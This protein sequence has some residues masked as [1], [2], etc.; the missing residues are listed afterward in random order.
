[1][2]NFK[3]FDCEDDG[4][5]TRSRS[6]PA[7][8]TPTPEPEPLPMLVGSQWVDVVMAEANAAGDGG[9][10]L[11]VECEEGEE[12]EDEASG[13]RAVTW[14][15]QV[16]LAGA[17]VPPEQR[18]RILFGEVIEVIEAPEGEVEGVREVDY[19]FGP[20]SNPLC[21]DPDVAEALLAVLFEMTAS[22]HR[23][24]GGPLSDLMD[25]IVPN[26]QAVAA[27]VDERLGREGGST[28]LF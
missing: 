10:H 1:M 18:R 27:A 7:E 11:V 24:D 17:G 22:A 21:L 19:Y 8:P 12:T 20:H 28:R 26:V 15:V 14:Y 4:G 3:R 25:L 13:E 23:A 16:H 5:D 2:S 6:D 9:V